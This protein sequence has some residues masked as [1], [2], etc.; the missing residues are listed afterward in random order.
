MSTVLEKN[1]LVIDTSVPSGL[2]SLRKASWEK[3]QEEELPTIK[4]ED[5]K[6]TR[7]AKLGKKGFAVNHGDVKEGIEKYFIPGM[8]SNKLVFVNGFFQADFSSLKEKE[9]QLISQVKEDVLLNALE[10]TPFVK[11]NIFTSTNQAY[12][13][14]GLFLQLEKNQKLN[15]PVELVFIQVGKETSAQIKNIIMAAE[16]SE[17]EITC[18]FYQTNAI[19]TLVNVAFHAYIS[20]NARVTVNKLQ[21]ERSGVSHISNE[22]IYQESDSV[23]TINTFSLYGELVRNDLHIVV[24]GTNC[25]SNLSSAFLCNGNMHVDNHTLVDHKMPHC[26]SNELYKGILADKSTGVFNGKVYV[27]RDAQKINAYQS[28]ANILLSDDAHIYTK[29]ELEIYAD[30]VKCS[31][32]STTGSLDEE[33]LFYLRARGLSEDSAKKLLVTAFAGDVVDK[34]ENEIIK[35]FIEEKIFQ[36]LEL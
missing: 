23:F 36:K 27:R 20:K 9:V 12:F 26:V 13:T 1:K 29:P 30:D 14:D 19:D 3:L 15:F 25:E 4:I 28:N 17:A 35:A 34:V 21:S 22:N 10:K 11:E 18:S 31:H 6:Y 7:V 2:S 16:G 32:G 33:A 24:N 8:E 5:W